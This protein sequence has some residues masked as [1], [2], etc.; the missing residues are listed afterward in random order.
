M[1]IKDLLVYLD[2]WEGSAKRLEAA[3]DLAANIRASVSALYVIRLLDLQPYMMGPISADILEADRERRLKEAEFVKQKVAEL[4]DRRGVP[5]EMRIAEGVAAPL[6]CL[7]GHYSDVIVA[8]PGGETDDGGMAAEALLGSGRPVL[9]VPKDGIKETIGDNI[10]VAWSASRESTR[11]LHDALPL[12][13]AAN[14]VYVGLFNPD[15]SGNGEPGQDVARHLARHGVNVTVVSEVTSELSV[16]DAI[17]NKAKVLGCDMVV[18]GGYGHS[19][20]REFAFGGVTRDVLT[21][22]A[23]PVF[24]SH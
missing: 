9:V 7:H 8:G 3:I 12:L 11:A 13:C 17:M 1:A 5:V 19:R 2:T 10:F 22:A 14:Q 20:L 24:M 4:A 15:Q 18:M 23:L 21:N 16:G 6:L